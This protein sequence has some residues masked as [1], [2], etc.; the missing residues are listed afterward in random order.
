MTGP[1][2]THWPALTGKTSLGARKAKIRG[3]YIGILLLKERGQWDLSR[4]LALL[5]TQSS[6]ERTLSPNSIIDLLSRRAISVCI[7]INI[8]ILFSFERKE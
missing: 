2:T 1:F 8:Y 3:L 4:Q 7:F 5:V 6:A